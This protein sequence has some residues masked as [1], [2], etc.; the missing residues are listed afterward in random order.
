M[1]AEL[2]G[3][4][5]RRAHAEVQDTEVLIGARLPFERYDEC[6]QL[7]LAK[8]ALKICYLPQGP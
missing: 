8:Q 7:L 4:E 3:V 2:E 5:L 1:S 6:V